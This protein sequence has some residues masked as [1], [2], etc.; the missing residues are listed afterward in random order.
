MVPAWSGAAREDLVERMN[1]TKGFKTPLPDPFITHALYNYNEDRI[2]SQIHNSGFANRPEDKVKIIFIP[3]YLKGDD[4][5][6]NLSYYDMLI[7]LDATA[8]PSYYEP[9]GYTPL[10][11]VAFGIP[12]VTTDLSGFGLWNSPSGTCPVEEKGV[13]VLHRTDSNYN[14]VADNLVATIKDLSGK[15]AA[16]IEDIRSLAVKTSKQALWKHLISYYEQA[17]DLALK[18]VKK[19]VK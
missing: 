5:I 16:E 18:N 3:S 10:E 19:T 11:S 6:L 13:A 15:T 14:E 1:A 17:Y 8:F 7:G 9:W 12:T 4:G 2:M